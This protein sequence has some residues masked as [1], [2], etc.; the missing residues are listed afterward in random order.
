[1]VIEDFNIMKKHIVTVIGDHFCVGAR[2]IC[3]FPNRLH[4]EFGK[5]SGPMYTAVLG[6][7]VS[8]GIRKV[9][10][11]VSSAITDAYSYDADEYTA[12][13]WVGVGD[14]KS[15][16]IPFSAWENM[17]DHCLCSLLAADMNVYVIIH[18]WPF[19]ASFF[20]KSWKKWVIKINDIKRRLCKK[21]GIW[22]IRVDVETED[23]ADLYS[24]KAKS[25]Q[26]VSHQIAKEVCAGLK[27]QSASE[28]SFPEV[29]QRPSRKRVDPVI[30]SNNN[31]EQ[32]MNLVI[33]AP[34]RVRH[35]RR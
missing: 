3:G 11:E 13:L 10:E 7:G 1:M 4:V 17:L 19:D 27:K 29:V 15:G 31:E 8:G 33:V 32:N 16:G 30:E 5:S 34:D 20:D 23:F 12:L 9:S 6:H 35:E 21:Y 26:Y 25:Y 28:D 24:L 14:L 18:N 22:F 2:D